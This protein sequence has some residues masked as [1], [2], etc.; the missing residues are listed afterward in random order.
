[1]NRSEAARQRTGLEIAIVG[2][3]GRFPGAGNVEEF[4]R[5]L[6]EGVDSISTFTDEELTEAAVSPAT[7]N[8]PHYVRA[9][10]VVEGADLFDAAFFGM[11]GKEAE[12][13]DPQHRQFLECAWEALESAGYHA[14]G[15][16]G[17]I[18]IYAGAGMNTYLANLLS[19]EELVRSVGVMLTGIGNEKDH[20]TTRVSYKLSLKGPAVT[21][22]TSCSTSLVAVS[23]ACQ[24][25]LSGACDMALAGGVSINLPQHAG[26]FYQEGGINSPDGRC[27]PFDAAANGTVP[28]NGV[29]V[30]VL[31]RLE[32]A[33]ADGDTLHAVI[34]G[35]AVNNDGSVKVG[36]TAPG[37]EGQT[38]VIKAAHIMAEVEPETIGYVE[39]HGTA[40]SLGDPVEFSALSQVFAGRGVRPRSCA[41]GSLKANVG[42]LDT[43]AGI[44]GLIKA[45]LALRHK[46]LPPSPY[47]RAPNPQ[48]DLSNSPFY[49]NA[50]PEAWE[51]TGEYPR[52]AGVSS[53]G[54][55][56]TNAHV[57][58]E[59]APEPEPSG[60]PQRAKHLLVL[61]ARSEAALGAAAERL[62]AHLEGAEG[63]G[64]TRASYLADAAHTLQVGRKAWSHRA[65]LVCESAGEAAERL[66]GG[67]GL[68]RGV[69][70]A[71]QRPRVVFM[72]P[73]Q[74][75]QYAGMCKEL[76]ER[77]ESFRRPFDEAAE[78]LRTVPGGLDVRPALW[79]AE[80]GE[81][82][83]ARLRQ[84]QVAQPALF[85]VEYGLARMWMSWGAEPW[86]MVG[87]SVG[88]LVAAVL[89]GVMSLEEGARLVAARGR[90]MQRMA[91]GAMAAVGLGEEELRER[92][93]RLHTGS[94]L[95]VAAANGPQLSVA[96]GSEEWITR[97]EAELEKEGVWVKRLRTSHAFHSAL[98]EPALEGFEAEVRR[99]RL[100]A[101]QLPYISNLSGEW[102]TAAE[103][104]D[105]GYWVRHLRGTVRFW[106]GLET[107]RREA[108]G[109]LLF[110]EVGP[111]DALTKLARLRAGSENGHGKPEGA[112]ARALTTLGGGPGVVGEVEA[113]LKAAGELWT[114]GVELDW[115]RLDGGARRRRVELPTYP[116][117]RQRYWVSAARPVG[118]LQAPALKKKELDEWFYVPVWKQTVAPL[119]LGGA[120]LGAEESDW[121][122]FVDEAGVADALVEGLREA[123]RTPVTVR[124]GEE[125]GRLGENE[126][127][128][129]PCERDDY[130]ALLADL[131]DE[132]LRPARILHLWSVSGTGRAGATR[133]AQELGFDSLLLLAQ[134]LGE[135]TLAAALADPSE[136][137]P[138][139]IVIVSD[140]LQ[141]VSEAD[142]VEPAKATLLGPCRVLPLEY[143]NLKC[144]SIDIEP[145]RE[146]LERDGLVEQLL[147]EIVGGEGADAVAYRGE[148]RWVQTFEPVR[149]KGDARGAHTLRERGVYFITGGLG[150]V[151]LSLA[152]YLAREARARLVLVGRRGLAEGSAEDGAAEKLKG[153]EALGAEVLLLQADV[154][155]E[156]QVRAAA[157]EARRRFGEINGVIH[158]AG[159]TPAG[160]AQLKTKEAAGRVLAPKVKGT[161]VLGAV[162]GG[163]GLDFIAL[164]SSLRSVVPGPGTVDYC[165]ANAFLDAFA[166]ARN[167][168]KGTRVLSINWDGWREVGMSSRGAEQGGGAGLDGE[169]MSPAEG[170]EAFGRVLR[171]AFPQVL[172]ST[173]DLNALVERERSFSAA[174]TLER[175]GRAQSARQSYGRPE[176]ATPYVAPR[177]EKEQTL[178]EIW[179]SLLGVERV[180]IHDNFFEL[181]GD[182]VIN[183]QIIARANQVGLALTARQV[184]EFQT[185]AELAAAAGDASGVEAEQ[186]AVTGPAPLTPIQRWFFEQRLEHP[187]H[188]NQAYLMEVSG[189]LDAA[190]LKEAVRHLLVHHDALRLRYAKGADGWEQAC[191]EPGGE[192]PFETLD[193]AALPEGEQARAVEETSAGLQASLNLSE[194]PLM[195]VALFD[196]GADRHARLLI[197][198]HHL[199]VDAVSWRIL[200]DDLSAAYQQL[201]QGRAV[202][203]PRKTTSF[204]QWARRLNEYAQSEPVRRAAEFWTAE[205]DATPAPLPLDFEGGGNTVAS[206]RQVTVSLTPEETQELL[207][208]APR[209]YH[210]QINDVLLTALSLSL[211]RWTGRDALLF[212]MEGH[213]REALFREVDLS[214]TVGWFTSLFPVPIRLGQADDEVAALR[215][216]KEQLRRVPN[217]GIDFGVLKYLGGDAEVAAR[218]S[219]LPRAEVIFLYLGQ[220]EEEQGGGGAAFRTA[221]ES[222]GPSRSPSDERQHVLEFTAQVVGGRLYLSLGYSENLHREKT[223]RRLADETAATLRSLLERRHTAGAG[224]Y[225]P[226]DFPEAGL[227]QSDLDEILAELS[228]LED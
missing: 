185:I 113:V 19:S 124:R 9:R 46:L 170:S 152:E 128:I 180:G 166:R 111:G 62:A 119:A 84:T 130:E 153:L 161:E 3:A 38:Q 195:R 11:S 225:T 12:I 202:E 139:E 54:I 182:S 123:G 210:T 94:A 31:K 165:A 159:V 226:S 97:L 133:D 203:L 49:V 61:S 57:V 117:E 98:M 132:G 77:E 42:H 204:Q 211:A 118:D 32:E 65:A 105:A 10:G 112:A 30:V 143:P 135:R 51:A 120:S 206:A 168:R 213:G 207:R 146:G 188:W 172:V 196:L 56:G 194:G 67:A 187:H 39:T 45:T 60:E 17:S 136:A 109:A 37:L 43:A 48:I 223:V 164:C 64:Q 81:G 222:A 224:A 155:D 24:G 201:E 53:F 141:K 193:L 138:I 228:E 35:S 179:Q 110:L 160:L 27:R 69:A 190:L 8:S 82:A 218:L 158:A 87:H 58:L 171:T 216:V 150:G 142:E 148:S 47:F 189:R 192:V 163:A 95:S 140:R 129:R 175:L 21:V 100:S 217:R 41:L 89:S 183:L 115:E 79:P 169:G 86:A 74:G 107:L 177:D 91:P 137:R 116:F 144:R 199:A 145:P 2:M 59:E 151:G 73:G 55:G 52:R 96:S 78:A 156:R 75:A 200:L 63:Q 92:I 1:M 131:D 90:L 15:Y 106:Q 25:L 174:G 44:A 28:G 18:G 72:F 4:W 125:F 80:V 83:E 33:L 214:R 219:S 220:Y 134:A 93:E 212:E 20:L 66:R 99:A 173:Q 178:A 34:R 29:G 23:L 114:A 76:C 227:S 184:F 176:L 191:A 167:S 209:F 215:E 108:G 121:L 198:I 157:E 122:I 88:E 13:T 26:Y 181:G 5:N 104:T 70:A 208:E 16:A 149:L 102:V 71:G 14:E 127:V 101:P 7:Y 126:Y 147:A 22:Q 186:G 205:A 50:A 85:A 103:A 154:T 68:L 40:T 36:Y 6:R 197:V 221:R 162:F